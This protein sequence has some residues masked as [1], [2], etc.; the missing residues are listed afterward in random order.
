M[1][2]RIAFHLNCLSQG[3]AER[4]VSTLANRFVD[5][6]YEVLV[7]TEWYGENEYPLD[8][9]VRRVHV[10]LRDTDASKSRVRK[11]L[12]RVKYLREFLKKERP[13]V[14]VAFDHQVDY[15]ALLAA[16][17]TGIPVV[18]SIRTNPTGHYDALTD[19]LQ[20]RCLFPEAAGCVYQTEGQRAFFRPYLQ[21]GTA[22]I[23]N[24]INDKYLH[25]P[26][27]VHREKAVMQS[28]RIVD[29][30]NQS[31]LFDAFAIVHQRHP[32]YCLRL[33]GSD[34]G[35]GT[36]QILKDKIRALGAEDWILL[37]GPCS[38]L[39]TELIKGAVYV[40]SSD[41]EGLPNGLMEAMALGLPCVSTDCPCGGPAEI[42]RDGE[43]GLLVPIQN[44]DA[45]AKAILTLIEDPEYA[46]AL[47]REARRIRERAGVDEICGQWLA[48]LKQAVAAYEERRQ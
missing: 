1:L 40:L 43:N 23:L 26:L 4:V 48:Y 13:D 34:S 11:I 15:R 12:L 37:C 39:E 9:R 10:G 32:D 28:A 5:E 2:K 31:M 35:D 16:R 44:A 47:G 41:W 19:R 45:M 38:H 18:I 6:G 17:G 30:K 33:Y 36:M 27:S 3:G 24:P 42:I 14:L 21:D 20:I 7:A 8:P 22:V 29:F 25:A 46:E